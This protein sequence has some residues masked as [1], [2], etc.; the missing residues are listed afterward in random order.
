MNKTILFLKVTDNK[1]SNNTAEIKF[2]KHKDKQKTNRQERSDWG[3]NMNLKVIKKY[4][5]TKVIFTIGRT[6]KN[7]TGERIYYIA[8][9][10][11][12]TDSKSLC[13]YIPQDFQRNNHNLFLNL[14]C[15]RKINP[16][17]QQ[18]KID[19]YFIISNG[20]RLTESL[21]NRVAYSYV[22]K[23]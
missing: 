5:P 21:G 2:D 15:L 9:I 12:L 22:A 17:N 18:Y 20:K 6:S 11:G 4:I 3:I 16:N 23:K 7:Y 8:D 10:I 19:D 14:K 1:N 13:R